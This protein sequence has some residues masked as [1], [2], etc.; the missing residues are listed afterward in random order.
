[1]LRS[2]QTYMQAITPTGQT[3]GVHP[4]ARLQSARTVV[5]WLGV[6]LVLVAKAS[7][8]RDL[9]RIGGTPGDNVVMD[10]TMMANAM[11]D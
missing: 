2:A 5:V 8:W 9:A 11:P 3:P 10:P 4:F 7:L 1:M 6:Y